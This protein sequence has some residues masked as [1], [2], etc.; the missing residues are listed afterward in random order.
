M[1]HKPPSPLRKFPQLRLWGP[2]IMIRMHLTT[3]EIPKIKVQ[4]ILIWFHNNAGTCL[5]KF[6][7]IFHFFSFFTFLVELSEDQ[8]QLK[9]Q[10]C[11]EILTIVNKLS[12]GQ[13]EIKGES[14]F[15]F[16]SFFDQLIWYWYILVFYFIEHNYWFI[17][18]GQSRKTNQR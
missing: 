7:T 10:I 12:L 14:I 9:K 2:L 15:F 11:E 8:L 3:Y 17:K 5:R 4:Q 6:Y 16:F 18:T 13:C 1:E